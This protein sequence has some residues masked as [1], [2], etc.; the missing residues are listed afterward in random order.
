MSEAVIVS[1]ARSP[2]RRPC[3][4]SLRGLRA[5]DLAA[6]MVRAELDQVPGLNPADITDLM[7]GCGL[8]E[9]AIA[10]GFQAADITPATLPDG[11]IV[12]ADDG[13]PPG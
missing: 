8:A 13:P 6:Q 1:V 3:K 11:T 9:Q 10:D 5:D 7:L 4:G 12:S 2:I